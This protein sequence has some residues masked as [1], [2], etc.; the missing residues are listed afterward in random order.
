VVATHELTKVLF[1]HLPRHR[2]PIT[3][4][5]EGGRRAGARHPLREV[6]IINVASDGSDADAIGFWLNRGILGTL[7]GH[8]RNGRHW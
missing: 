7:I 3:S 2:G 6:E 4:A 5:A 1:V 8:N